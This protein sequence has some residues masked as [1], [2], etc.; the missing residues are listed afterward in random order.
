MWKFVWH[1]GRALTILTQ[2]RFSL[3]SPVSTLSIL[4]GAILTLLGPVFYA[5]A[6]GHA[7]FTALIPSVLGIGI[8]IAGIIAR[9]PAK[10]KHAAHA[11]LGLGLFGILGSLM[12]AGLWPKI[13]THQLVAANRPLAVK[14]QFVMFVVC[15]IYL[16]FGVR[17]FIAARKAGGPTASDPRLLPNE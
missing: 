5:K 17:S 11:G 13:F 8:L 14:E 9:N 10:R 16:L 2:V 6:H 15:T 4:F 3:R 1:Q 7:H 12:S